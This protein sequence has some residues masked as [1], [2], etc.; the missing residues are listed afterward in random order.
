[1]KHISRFLVHIGSFIFAAI[2]A[3]AFISVF[4]RYVLNN[5]IVWAEEVMRYAFIWMFFLCMPEATR[6]ASHICLDIIPS[7]IHGKVKTI[8]E[9][10]IEVINIVFL[11]IVV[12]FGVKISL[13]NMSQTSAALRIPYGCIYFALPTG[14]VLMMIFCAYRLYRILLNKTAEE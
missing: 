9:V 6:T 10:L 1:M 4:F 12:Y 11:F 5:S 2:L 7:L 8:V 13:I 3:V 14:A